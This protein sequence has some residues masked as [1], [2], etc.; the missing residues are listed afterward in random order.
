MPFLVEK[1]VS[2]GPEQK[3]LQNCLLTRPVPS[4]PVLLLCQSSLEH[5]IS[6]AKYWSFWGQNRELAQF[7]RVWA[8]DK[9][10]L[11][12]RPLFLALHVT[13]GFLQDPFCSKLSKPVM[14]TTPQ[15]G[16]KDV[17]LWEMLLAAPQARREPSLSSI[18]LC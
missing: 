12:V 1:C 7:S 4:F 11:N 6:S 14:G 2:Q 9:E 10:T 13:V 18:N 8:S 3:Q 5:S 16:I 17:K 15:K